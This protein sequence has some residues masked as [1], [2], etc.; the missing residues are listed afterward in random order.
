[1]LGDF[2]DND[3]LAR[4]AGQVGVGFIPVVGTV[5]DV[6]D[7]VAAS[8]AVKNGEPGAR[9]NLAI[10]VAA[11]VPGLDVLKAG[12][13]AGAVDDVGS[14]VI[15]V[16]RRTDEAQ[17]VGRAA[18][19]A[20]LALPP[21]SLPPGTLRVPGGKPVP[22]TTNRP[23]IVHGN[24]RPI[25][26]NVPNSTVPNADV[27][28]LPDGEQVV[29]VQRNGDYFENVD[30]RVITDGPTIKVEGLE[31]SP[32]VDVVING[33]NYN[34]R[35]GGDVILRRQGTAAPAD[36]PGGK[37]FVSTPDGE[38]LVGP[39]DFRGQDFE[40]R[41]TTNAGTPVT[42]QFKSGS[43]DNMGPSGESGILNQ[44]HTGTGDNVGNG[45]EGNINQNHS[46]SGDNVGGVKRVH[47][48]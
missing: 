23:V 35:V 5:A 9:V 26:E 48:K 19:R 13:A 7:I 29:I 44:R 43:G 34:E 4:V 12:K 24:G 40:T 33:G 30:G 15:G 14:A 25:F 38:V 1:M 20:P 21:S 16:V 42:T 18:N 45:F 28:R 27:I 39:G 47:T 2:S 32:R 36:T 3:S 46:G 37:T 41:S 8:Q 6:R 11:I 10:A 31:N 17:A 22:I